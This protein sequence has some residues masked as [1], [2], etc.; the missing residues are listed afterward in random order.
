MA[1]QPFW[2]LLTSPVSCATWKLPV[3]QVTVPFYTNRLTGDHEI[4]LAFREF[5]KTVSVTF[6]D[7]TSLLLSDGRRIQM[8]QSTTLTATFN[9][10]DI[11]L[12][13]GGADSESGIFFEGSR[14]TV[15]IL[16]NN[17]LP[18]MTRIIVR[19]AMHHDAEVSLTRL[20]VNILGMF[21]TMSNTSYVPAPISKPPTATSAAFVTLAQLRRTLPFIHALDADAAVVF[22]DIVHLTLAM[23]PAPI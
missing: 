23:S 1:L 19:A 12:P 2:T 17:S 6:H 14:L 13:A 10:R 5:G 7:G 22:A 8:E 3:E 21:N 9:E 4:S 15:W 11:T 18:H 20:C 16:S